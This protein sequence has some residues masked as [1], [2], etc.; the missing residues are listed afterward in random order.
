MHLQVKREYTVIYGYPEEGPYRYVPRG[1]RFSRDEVRHIAI[2]MVAL[3]SSFM[4]L[5]TVHGLVTAGL[6]PLYFAIAITAAFT[7]FLFHELMHKYFAQRFGAWAE[8]R[9]SIGGLLLG[10]VTSFLGFI[11]AAPG[12]VYISGMLDR[13]ETGIVS[14]AGPMTNTFFSFIFLLAAILLPTGGL[15]FIF[16]VSVAFLD[17]ILGV[18]NMLPIPPLDGLKVLRWN[19]PIY[20]AGLILPAIPVVFLIL[21]NLVPI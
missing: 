17:G 20:V 2:A 10:L 19:V 6:L 21:T 14:L 15:P 4:I 11:L 3:I 7:G 1:M 8:F 9:Y 16:L 18:F 12:A 5:Y 13:R